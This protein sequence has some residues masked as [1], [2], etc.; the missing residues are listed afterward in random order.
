MK[1]SRIAFD[2]L[3]W[4]LSSAG[5]LSWNDGDVN[6]LKR[7]SNTGGSGFI[8]SH[9][10]YYEL[11]LRALDSINSQESDVSIRLPLYEKAKDYPDVI[12]LQELAWVAQDLDALQ[13]SYR[14]VLVKD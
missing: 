11:E 3:H 2:R 8:R 5:I 1:L 9:S 13:S 7:E 12:P 6:R 10:T 4:L 14:L